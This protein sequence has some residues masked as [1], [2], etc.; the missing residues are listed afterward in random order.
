M[1][2]VPSNELQKLNN[3]Q[4]GLFEQICQKLLGKDSCEFIKNEKVD[5]EKIKAFLYAKHQDDRCLKVWDLVVKY[6]A[7]EFVLLSSGKR[8][9]M[10]LAFNCVVCFHQK[11]FKGA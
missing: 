4:K 8:L 9:S 3:V 10:P 5:Y 1:G 11:E 2:S 6:Y 7:N